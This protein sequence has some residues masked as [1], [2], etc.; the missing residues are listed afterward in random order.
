[1]AAMRGNSRPRSAVNVSHAVA[2][3][4]L[5]DRAQISVGFSKF[6]AKS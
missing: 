2:R 1:L 5:E 6:A 3:P 4:N